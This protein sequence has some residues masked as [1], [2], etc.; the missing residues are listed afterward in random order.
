LSSSFQKE[1][2]GLDYIHTLDVP[3][4]SLE[5]YLANEDFS[6]NHF[7]EQF[8]DIHPLK[9]EER[10]RDNSI[11][12]WIKTKE[13]LPDDPRT[14]QSAMAYISDLGLLHSTLVPHGYE[15]KTRS[16]KSPVILASIDHVIWFHRP[17]RVDEWFFYDCRV[18]STSGGRG[19]A[20]GRLYD[21]S[22]T[23]V[24]STAQEGMLRLR[25]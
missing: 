21:K 6:T 13:N 25:R 4:A 16:K 5:Q 18:I 8:L 7:Q 17:F 22:G 3:I 2:K 12:L 11:Q 10:T 20:D 24:A 9:E 1:E 14:H 23:L 15:H 19:L